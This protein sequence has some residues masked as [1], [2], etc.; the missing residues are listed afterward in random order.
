MSLGCGH[1]SLCIPG[2][3]LGLIGLIQE[4]TGSESDGD[5]VGVK[6]GIPAVG[7]ED[8]ERRLDILDRSDTGVL[9]FAV[10]KSKGAVGFF[11]VGDINGHNGTKITHRIAVDGS[12]PGLNGDV[13][14]GAVLNTELEL[15]TEHAAGGVESTNDGDLHAVPVDEFDFIFGS[16]RIGRIG[17]AVRV[18]VG[19]CRGAGL[20]AASGQSK[21][22]HDRGEQ[23]CEFFQV[24]HTDSS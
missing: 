2:T 1:G 10:V 14:A 18:R 15:R 5:K 23:E 19:D 3:F 8:M 21:E 11:T 20:G 12:F 6:K 24:F 13:V 7:V 9:K 16:G 4:R 17:R 22:H